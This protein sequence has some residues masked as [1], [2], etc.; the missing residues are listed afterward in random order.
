M[1]LIKAN[2]LFIL[3]IIVAFALRF[4]KL[5]SVPL[6]LDWDE[7][8]NGY[9]AYSILHTAHDE[10]GSFL[11]LAN[12][13]FDDYKPPLYMYLTV[14]AIAIFGLN[15]FAVRLPS[16]LFGFLTVP[17]IFL[18]AQFLF[19]E[20][21]YKKQI[22]LITM[23]LFAISPWSIQFSRVGFEANVALFF[24]ILSMVLLLYSFKKQISLIFS[25]VAACLS[26]YAY[27]TQKIFIPLMFL[28]LFAIFIKDLKLFSKKII[29]SFFIITFLLIT[30]LFLFGP[31]EALLSRYQ[32]TSRQEKILVSENSIKLISEDNNNYFG[33]IIH[34]RKI[35]TLLGISQNYL[36]NFDPNFL[37]IKGDENPRH[38]IENMGMFYLFQ[39]PLFLAGLYLFVAKHNKS[40]LFI[41]SWLF[42]APIAASFAAPSPHAIRS[43][44]MIVPVEIICAFGL[45][46]F[47]D[48]K[49][50]NKVLL[51][52]GAL[53][54]WTVISILIY[55]HNYYVHYPVDK[56]ADWQ[57]GFKQAVLE[58]ENRKDKYSEVS[59]DPSLEQAYVYWLF[60]TKY[61]PKTYQLSGSNKHFDKYYF[62]AEKPKTS[63]KLF[64]SLVDTAIYPKN[65][66][67]VYKIDYP[68]GKPAIS[69]T[70]HP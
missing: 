41:F 19:K 18:L 47:L 56:A 54:V 22:G 36:S 30:P 61:D 31:K 57:Y 23:F 29:I 1:K 64:I 6:S 26:I 24:T 27:H 3:I 63:D 14:P 13:S 55:F 42:L 62:N 35:I 53:A 2:L 48:I 28:A 5:G 12:R 45:T 44:L 37:F 58:S 8:S 20:S 66:K 39:L 43:F 65:F 38:H 34:N 9:N 15:E 4:Y 10:Y 32:T 50:K 49:N 17:L 67:V 70:Q 33:R 21:K 51:T 59:V 69:L 68:N 60:Y 46:S 11:P 25:A 7:V 52:G 16:A 40:T